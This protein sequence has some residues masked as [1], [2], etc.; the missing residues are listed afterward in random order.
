MEDV[1]FSSLAQS[2]APA[3]KVLR[4]DG[5]FSNF[6]HFFFHII[7]VFDYYCIT[8]LPYN[9]VLELEYL[10]NLECMHFCMKVKGNL[11]TKD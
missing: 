7:V 9:M 8:K 3:W 2:H 11:L 6:S 10:M 5:S 1:G 4:N